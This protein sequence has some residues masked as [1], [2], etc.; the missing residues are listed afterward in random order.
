[1]SRTGR[2]EWRKLRREVLNRDDWICQKCGQ[3]GGRLEVHHKTRV[4]DSGADGSSDDPEELITYCVKCH[5]DH[6]RRDRSEL[7]QEWD[8]YFLA[9]YGHH[10]RYNKSKKHIGRVT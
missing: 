6:H 1:M 10:L 3:V 7:S 8:A 4:R 5:I 9:R 2:A